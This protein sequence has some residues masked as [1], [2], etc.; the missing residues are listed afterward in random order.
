MKVIKKNTR[1]TVQIRGTISLGTGLQGLGFE[2]EDFIITVENGVSGIIWR[3]MRW[4]TSL[5]LVFS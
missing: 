5:A 1:K 4:P 2:N 3:Q